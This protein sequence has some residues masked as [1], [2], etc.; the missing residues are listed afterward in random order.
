MGSTDFAFALLAANPFGGLLVAIP[1][2]VLKLHYSGWL[3]IGIGAPL[4]YLQVAVVDAG[5]SLLVRIP[6]GS[7]SLIGRAA[8]ES[9]VSSPRAARSGSR[10][11]RRRSSDPG[12]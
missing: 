6:V 1:F 5:W 8:P 3:A 11:L 10:S 12:S 4:A 9:G 2:A 7:D